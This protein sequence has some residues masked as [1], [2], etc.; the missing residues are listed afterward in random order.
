MGRETGTVAMQ[1]RDG[2]KQTP[3]LDSLSPWARRLGTQTFVNRSPAPGAV[4]K[5]PDFSHPG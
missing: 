5:G 4:G 3:E 1:L 2:W